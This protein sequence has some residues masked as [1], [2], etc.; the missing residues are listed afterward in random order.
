LNNLTDR[1]WAPCRSVGAASNL[2]ALLSV[3][4]AKA[5]IQQGFDAVDPRLRGNDKLA[6]SDSI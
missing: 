6:G 5:G 1:F 3:M 2:P 4:P